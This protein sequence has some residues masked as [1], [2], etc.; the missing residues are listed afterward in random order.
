M[1]LVADFYATLRSIRQDMRRSDYSG[2]ESDLQ[3]LETAYDAVLGKLQDL[4]TALKCEGYVDC[5]HCKRFELAER[6]LAEHDEN[7]A[8]S[9]CTYCRKDVNADAEDERE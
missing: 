4:H 2:L 9:Y 8:H 6:G 3:E 5:P 7:P 1:N